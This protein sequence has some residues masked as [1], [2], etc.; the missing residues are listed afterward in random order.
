MTKDADDTKL[1]ALSAHQLY[2]GGTYRGGG[3]GA[4]WARDKGEVYARLGNLEDSQRQLEEEIQREFRE[5]RREFT[6]HR[7]EEAEQMAEVRDAIGVTKI[8]I[9]RISI[10]VTVIC[11]LAA[12]AGSVIVPLVQMLG[13]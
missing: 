7:K 13:R 12:A 3:N 2:G 8:E 11:G 5:Y 9:A 6:D 10:K 1:S 4:D